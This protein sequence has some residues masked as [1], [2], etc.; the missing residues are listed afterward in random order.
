MVDAG[1]S[2]KDKVSRLIS[3]G[4]WFVFANILLAMLAAGRYIVANG[5]PDTLL[6]GFYLLANWGGHFAFLAMVLY[7]VVLF[8]L[9]FAVP[10]SRPL[11]AIGAVIAT[12]AILL[13]L[14]DSSIYKNYHLHINLLIFDLDGFK[15]GDSIGWPTVGVFLLA[16]LAVELTLANL[17]WKRLH[18][19]RETNLG[20][21]ISTVFISAFLI[22]H[23]IHIWA[24][25]TVYQPIVK[26][27]RMFPL[28]YPSTA[29]SFMTRHG[30]IDSEEHQ[31]KLRQ[32]VP[33]RPLNYPLAPLQCTSEST[34]DVLLI[35]VDSINADLVNRDTMPNLS[36]LADQGVAFNQHLSSNYYA[37]SALFSLFTG[38]PAD[39]KQAFAGNDTP[40]AMIRVA[41]ELGYDIKAFGSERY[42]ELAHLFDRPADPA[43]ELAT[44]SAAEQDIAATNAW[45]SWQEQRDAAPAISRISYRASDRFSTPDDFHR[46]IKYPPQPEL[47]EKER[48]LYRQYLQSLR[49]VDEQIGRL[50]NNVDLQKTTVIVTAARGMEPK[51]LIAGSDNFSLANVRVPMI[52][53]L[54]GQQ[55]D[56]IEQRTS[57]YDLV[58]TLMAEHF[59]CS[60][61]TGDYSIGRN[62]FADA[63][64]AEAA[65]PL[66]FIGEANRFALYQDQQISVIDRHGNYNFYDLDYRKK[67]DGKLSFQS[68][69][70]LMHDQQRFYQ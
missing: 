6:G 38:L 12:L 37:D 67:R 9:T 48:V 65:S 23:L 36:N 45:L 2:Y 10:Y 41:S 16:L 7:I 19:F 11:R 68:L 32:N 66:L 60:N 61:D 63:P 70:T 56:R 64:Q 17:I 44:A 62:L 35:L 43:T 50:L 53:A 22:S 13:L 55:S 42:P 49:F 52:I 5:L 31:E 25:A 28:S 8:P 18:K 20:G 29:R 69:I 54:P 26:M 27:D 51:A 34:N 46:Y 40:A 1:N 57:H 33:S 3:W 15:L 47:S 14:V 39:Y 59:G 30:W 24:D 4:H 58:P 21:N